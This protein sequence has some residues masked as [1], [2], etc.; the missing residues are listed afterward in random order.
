[1]IHS[2]TTSSPPKT[3]IF[4]G[5][6]RLTADRAVLTGPALHHV[7]TVLRLQPSASRPL[8]SKTTSSSPGF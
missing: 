8:P 4:V 6:E 3:R 5:D 1:M 2:A 7:Q